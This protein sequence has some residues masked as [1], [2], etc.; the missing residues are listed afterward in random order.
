MTSGRRW[1]GVLSRVPAGARDGVVPL[2]E[3]VPT[4]R[5]IPGRVVD[6]PVTVGISFAEIDPLE[7]VLFGVAPVDPLPESVEPQES[8]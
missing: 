5:R 3:Q 2:Q 4:G 6:D 1:R 7:H 8:W